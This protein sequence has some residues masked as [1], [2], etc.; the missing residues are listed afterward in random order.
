MKKQTAVELLVQ[1]IHSEEYQKA[2]GQTYISIE[3]VEQAK[4][5]EK[6][7]IKNAYILPLSSEYWFKDEDFFQTESEQYYNQNYES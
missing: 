5:M 1:Y 4:A 2:F 6:E 3:L 7:Q